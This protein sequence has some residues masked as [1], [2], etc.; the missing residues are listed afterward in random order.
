MLL[1][2]GLNPTLTLNTYCWAGQRPS[3]EYLFQRS[4]YAAEC[5][6]DQDEWFANSY[7]DVP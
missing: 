1:T 7:R 4:I 2:N 5:S 3:Y 6:A